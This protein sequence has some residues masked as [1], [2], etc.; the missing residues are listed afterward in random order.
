MP[1]QKEAPIS[2][3]D[4]KTT[5][6]TDESA[7]SQ[8]CRIVDHLKKFGK[9]T[10]LEAR[11]VLGIMNPAQRVSELRKGGKP[12]DTEWAFQPDETGAVHRVAAYVWRSGEAR[13]PDLLEGL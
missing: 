6:P 8:G 1:A 9:L 5:S 2:G 10:T 7:A 11:S 3:A 13:Q 4:R 12:I